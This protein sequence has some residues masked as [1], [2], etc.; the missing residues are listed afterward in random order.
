LG[1]HFF[2]FG[3]FKVILRQGLKNIFVILLI[4]SAVFNAELLLAQKKGTA[5]SSTS[6]RADSIKLVSLLRKEALIR[7]Q[8]SIYDAR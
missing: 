2:I 1:S 4:I 3:K 5:K 6:V 7:K 8:D